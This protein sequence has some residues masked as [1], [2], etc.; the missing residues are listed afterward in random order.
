MTINE[1]KD[2]VLVT[3]P[4]PLRAEGGEWTVLV[5]IERP[6]VDPALPKI[7]ADLIEQIIDYNQRTL[8]IREHGW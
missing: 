3:G 7:I 1:I 2:G 6:Q 8:K 4:L 5:T